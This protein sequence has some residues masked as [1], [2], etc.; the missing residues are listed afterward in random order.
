MRAAEGTG[1]LRI[2]AGAFG[3][4]LQGVVL[5]RRTPF[6]Q[7]HLADNFGGRRFASIDLLQEFSS[8]LNNAGLSDE[9]VKSKL[10]TIIKQHAA[11]LAMNDAFLLASYLFAGLAVLVW[12]AH[13]AY[14]HLHPGKIEKLEDLRAEEIMEEP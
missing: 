1:L 2:A 13:P 7:L 14:P 8:K 11:I 4:T 5:F 9:M 3:I 10:L 6:H 12:L